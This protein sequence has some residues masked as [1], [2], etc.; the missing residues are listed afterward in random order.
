MTWPER[1]WG[2]VQ[3]TTVAYGYRPWRAV[4]WLVLLLTAGSVVYA[5]SPPAPLQAGAAP[6]FNPVVY[7]FDLLLPIVD[8]GQKHA[9]NPAGFDQWFSY[10]LVAAGWVLATT[11]AAGIARV[12]NR[13]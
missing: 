2:L 12:V 10:L 5:V 9:Y 1:A 3:D 11:I 7:T 6:H 8:L 13:S 4:L